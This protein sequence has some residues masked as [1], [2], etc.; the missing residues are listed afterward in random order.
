MTKTK[1]NAAPAY[2]VPVCETVVLGTEGVLCGS[3]FGDDG[4]PGDNLHDGGIFDF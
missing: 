2:Q 3:Y 4:E 1:S